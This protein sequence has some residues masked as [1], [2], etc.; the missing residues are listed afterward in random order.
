MKPWTGFLV[1]WVCMAPIAC[2]P[3]EKVA[4]LGLQFDWAQPNACSEYSPEIHVTGIPSGIRFLEVCLT[5]RY[6]PGADHGGWG[7][8]PCP[9]DGIIPPGGLDHY[10][11][12]CPPND[13]DG[14]R[15]E[16]VVRAIDGD[17]QVAGE[18]R[19]AKQCCPQW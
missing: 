4:T 16:F 15:Y 9:A 8:I 18:G 11:G 14:G 19:L 2:P 3:N 7:R 12:P 5:D 10:R 1:L 6:Q 17:D 13:D